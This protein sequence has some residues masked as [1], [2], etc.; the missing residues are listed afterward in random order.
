MRRLQ[1]RN[2]AARLWLAPLINWTLR[3]VDGNALASQNDSGAGKGARAECIEFP[4]HALSGRVE[5]NGLEPDHVEIPGAAI[6]I[7]DSIH[8]ASDSVAE[9]GPLVLSR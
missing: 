8:P 9:R 5:L 2:C 4:G 6:D 7:H 1:I 3:N